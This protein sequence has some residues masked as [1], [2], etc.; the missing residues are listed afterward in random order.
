MARHVKANDTVEIIAGDH[1]G[2]RGKVLRV[3][4]DKRQV[5]VEGHAQREPH[6]PVGLGE[7]RLDRADLRRAPPFEDPVDRL[8]VGPRAAE[9]PV[10]G[11]G[12]LSAL[13]GHRDAT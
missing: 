7:R 12:V 4:P 3:D 11:V 6:G 8:L 13:R 10:Q 9:R 2:A 1:R 5:V